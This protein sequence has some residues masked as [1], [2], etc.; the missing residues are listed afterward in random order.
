MVVLI[1]SRSVLVDV[2]AASRFSWS[3]FNLPKKALI[4]AFFYA[5]LL[6]V[7]FGISPIYANCAMS[8]NSEIVAV[9]KVVDGDTVILHGGVKVRLIGINTPELSRDGRAEEPLAIAA[10]I[11]LTKLVGAGRKLRLQ[12]GQDEYDRYGRMLAYL[13]LPDGRSVEAA[14]LAAGLGHH[15]GIPP[16]LKYLGCMQAAERVAQVAGRGVWG[17]AYFSPLE[18][19]RLTKENSGF[20]RVK[21]VVSRIDKGAQAWWLELDG[22]LVLR[23]DRSD[24]PSFDQHSLNKLQGKQIVVR[25]W[26]VDRSRSVKKNSKYKPWLM[27]LRQP[28]AIENWPH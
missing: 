20:R 3:S 21:G 5:C 28:V 18:S 17:N 23:I 13:F 24:L 8:G 2:V 16:N 7:G 19:S 11:H 4:S 6:L 14:L 25:G 22:D 1:D 27:Q 9:K 10:R 12:Q 26:L 15:I